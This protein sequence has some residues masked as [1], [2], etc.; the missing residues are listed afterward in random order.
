[1]SEQKNLQ[2]DRDEQ[3]RLIQHL[4]GIC[5]VVINTVYG[6]FSLSDIAVARYKE[7]AGIKENDA[8]S[9]YD[10]PRD[11]AYLVTTVKELGEDAN[12]IYS[13]LKI[14]EV[15]ADVDWY[16]DEYDG[17]EWVAEKHRTWR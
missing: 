10:I 5:Y 2:V 1:M 6:G 13:D 9:V 3:E 8:W 12:G 17:R 11:D 16:I 7:L 4:R 14:V 15:P